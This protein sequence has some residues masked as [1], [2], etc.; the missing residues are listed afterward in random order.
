VSGYRYNYSNLIDFDFATFQLV[1]RSDVDTTGLEVR[2]RGEIGERAGWSVFAATLNNDVDGVDNALLH[3]PERSAGGYI[4]FQAGTH[5]LATAAAA[6]E[7]RRP[8]SSIPGGGETLDSYTRFNLAIGRTLINNL[9]LRI[10]ID[11]LFD[12]DYEAVAGFPA[13]GRQLRIGL[14]QGF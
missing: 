13:P 6:Y 7:G 5:W 1:N 2:L 3:R 14:R 8:S 4:S 12:T 10:A 11:N 9:S